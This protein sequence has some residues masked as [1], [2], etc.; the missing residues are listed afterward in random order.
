MAPLSAVSAKIRQHWH[1]IDTLTCHLDMSA[2]FQAKFRIRQT[3]VYWQWLVELGRDG[4]IWVPMLGE[5]YTK[6]DPY[7]GPLG[8]IFQRN[9]KRNSRFCRISGH[10]NP[11]RVPWSLCRSL[12]PIGWRT[13]RCDIMTS[14][15]TRKTWE[16]TRKNINRRHTG[17][18]SVISVPWKRE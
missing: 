11:E 18:K 7:P 9:S 14:R 3:T 16:Y 1:N 13:L 10:H 12:I 17:F 2:I 5:G 4:W 8:S 6:S 15:R